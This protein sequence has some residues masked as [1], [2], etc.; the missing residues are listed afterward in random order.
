MFRLGQGMIAPALHAADFLACKALA[1]DVLP[2]QFLMCGE[3]IGFVLRRRAR[4]SLRD[5]H[6]ALICDVRTRRVGEP[7]IA[8][9]RHILDT[10]GRQKRRCCR[11]RRTGAD[12]QDIGAEISHVSFLQN[13]SGTGDPR[14]VHRNPP[15]RPCRPGNSQVQ[16]ACPMGRGSRPR[17]HR[18]T[19]LRSSSSVH[20]AP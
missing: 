2:H 11:S 14:D 17:F 8:V 16:A 13:R 4:G 1:E 3:Q 9:D 12:D 5:L 19:G 10:V 20:P 15:R 7:A 6:G 18:R